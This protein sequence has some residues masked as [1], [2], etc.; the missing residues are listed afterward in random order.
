MLFRGWILSVWTAGELEPTAE[1]R[2]TFRQTDPHVYGHHV[3]GYRGPGNL[4]LGPRSPGAER[5]V[6][7][8]ALTRR[9]QMMINVTSPLTPTPSFL[10]SQGTHMPWWL[11]VE[12]GS[13][14]W[15]AFP[16]AARPR[17]GCSASYSLS[18]LICKMGMCCYLLHRR[19]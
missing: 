9:K 8:H 3:V 4:A 12:T 17:A 15:L 1:G 19:L 14:S 6:C 10:S 16:Q 7:L 11:R 13:K 2:E 18:I 5:Q